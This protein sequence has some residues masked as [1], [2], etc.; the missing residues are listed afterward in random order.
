MEKHTHLPVSMKAFA[1]SKLNLESFTNIE[2]SITEVDFRAKYGVGYEIYSKKGIDKFIDTVGVKLQ[3]ISKAKG[4][5]ATKDEITKGLI[6]ELSQLER[7]NVE[8]AEGNTTI[9]FVKAKENKEELKKANL[10]Y[11]FN[12]D[13]IVF[14]KSGKE[15]KEKLALVLDKIEDRKG[16][17][18]N[19]RNKLGDKIADKPTEPLSEYDTEGHPSLEALRTFHWAKTS[20]NNG[21]QTT[22]YSNSAKANIMYPTSKE[23]ADNCRIFNDLTY[24]LV[25]LVKDKKTLEAFLKNIDEAGSYELTLGQLTTLGF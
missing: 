10:N 14:K 9:V 12:S 7:V 8:N 15:I 18:E 16:I 24:K 25:C 17:V 5:Q 3:E 21:E 11:L 4:T 22:A 1:D 23:E 20:F 13:K 6:G 19:D 2:K